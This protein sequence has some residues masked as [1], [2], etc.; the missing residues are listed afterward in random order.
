MGGRTA[1][2]SRNGVPSAS[3]QGLLQQTGLKDGVKQRIEDRTVLRR[4]DQYAREC[5]SN[6][7][8]LRDADDCECLDGDQRALR[9]DA[10]SCLAKKTHKNREVPDQFTRRSGCGCSHGWRECHAEA[11]TDSG[12]SELTRSMSS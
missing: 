11:G 4:I 1:G 12:A 10:Q 3:Q 5:A 8:A 9:P 6:I 7:L 2:G